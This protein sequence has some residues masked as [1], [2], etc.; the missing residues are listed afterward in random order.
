MADVHPLVTRL[1]Q[2]IESGWGDNLIASLDFGERRSADAQALARQLDALCD[3]A[4]P[5]KISRVN[6]RG[7]PRDGRLVVMGQVILQVRDPS[8]PTRQFALQAEFVQ[9][10][11]APVLTRLAPASP[12]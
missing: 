6:L 2:D 1:L 7:E 4:R 3:G 12:Q 10:G 8:M 11:G 5:V 9:R